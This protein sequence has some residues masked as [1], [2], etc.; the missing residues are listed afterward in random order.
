METLDQM[1]E[2]Q[3][4]E[5]GEFLQAQA[6]SWKALIAQYDN[7]ANKVPH[8]VY[9]QWQEQYGTPRRETLLAQ[10]DAENKAYP[11][12]PFDVSHQPSPSDAAKSN[13]QPEWLKGLHDR[14]PIKADTDKDQEKDKEDDLDPSKD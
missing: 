11:N 9:W 13:Y 14:A 6:T 2:R 1:W 3:R 4:K 7:D 12:S 10:H 8:D 5:M